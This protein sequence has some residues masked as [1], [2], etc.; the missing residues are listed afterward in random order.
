MKNIYVV[1]LNRDDDSQS[2]VKNL[3]AFTKKSSAEDFK[4][5]VE[6]NLVFLTNPSVH[7]DAYEMYDYVDNKFTNKYPTCYEEHGNQRKWWDD[8]YPF[9]SI[10]R[11]KQYVKDIK[12]SRTYTEQQLELIYNAYLNEKTKYLDEYGGPDIVINIIEIP[13]NE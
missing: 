5:K 8:N 9:Y 7:N 10:Y 2:F 11:F 6:K 12:L 1:V 3:G 13:F 4:K